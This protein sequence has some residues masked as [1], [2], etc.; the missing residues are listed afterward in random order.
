[1]GSIGSTLYVALLRAHELERQRKK[2]Q[3]QYDD[4]RYDKSMEQLNATHALS[5][6]AK[7]AEFERKLKMAQMLGQSAGK[8]G[9]DKPVGLGNSAAQEWSNAAYVG[10]EATRELDQQKRARELEDQRMRGQTS[11]EDRIV[12]LSNNPWND[13]TEEA[14]ALVPGIVNRRIPGANVTGPLV[15][16]MTPPMKPVGGGRNDPVM[17]LRKEFSGR[18]NQKEYNAAQSQVQAIQTAAND[19]AGDL[20]VIMG[21]AR[22]TQPGSR[23]VTDADFTNF[24][25]AGGAG[26]KIQ[27]LITYWLENQ[28]LPPG[29]RQQMQQESMRHFNAKKQ[30]AQKEAIWY[31]RDIIGPDM[32]PEQIIPPSLR[33]QEEQPTTGGATH[34]LDDLL[35]E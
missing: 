19:G 8:T 16:R 12:G 1:M 17:T 21:F 3:A 34:P 32:S 23:G 18:P 13:P 35:G 10:G 28:R 29:V 6:T 11:M 5:E 24:A 26:S 33:G 2:E 30:A 31:Q 14:D 4:Q 27:S 9:R 20:T 7:N 22:I 15:N 25:A